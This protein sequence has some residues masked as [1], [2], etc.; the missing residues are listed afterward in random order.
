MQGLK[1]PVDWSLG[2]YFSG[3]RFTN[4]LE[5]ATILYKKSN[6]VLQLSLDCLSRSMHFLASCYMYVLAKHRKFSFV[7]LTRHLFSKLFAAGGV[8]HA[9][10]IESNDNGKDLL[11][12]GAIDVPWARVH[13]EVR[14]LGLSWA[15]RALYPFISSANKDILQDINI[16]FPAGEVTAILVSLRR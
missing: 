4:V 3:T 8:K 6:D 10:Q 7:S 15:R 11:V 16:R 9:Q 12:S 5:R 1:I 13:V 2:Y 14:G